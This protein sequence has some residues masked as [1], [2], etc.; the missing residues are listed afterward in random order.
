LVGFTEVALLVERAVKIFGAVEAEEV[1]GTVGVAT[2]GSADGF[3]R[4]F[5]GL[6]QKNT[7]RQAQQARQTSK[8]KNAYRIAL[9]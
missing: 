4:V 3:V 1:A 2:F 6:G 8:S 5:C 9:S 7:R